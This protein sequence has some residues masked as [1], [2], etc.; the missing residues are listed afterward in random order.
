MDVVEVY[1]VIVMGEILYVENFGLVGFGEVG[2][3]VENGDFI[4]GG[5]ILINLL[6]GL[7]FKGYLLGVIGF[8]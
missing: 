8:G 7:E 1:D 2:L 5:C 6:G 4:I 3:V